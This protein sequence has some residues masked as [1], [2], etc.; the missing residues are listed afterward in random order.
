MKLRQ[1]ILSLAIV[2]LVA[3]GL[4]MPALAADDTQ[5]L[6]ITTQVAPTYTVVIPEATSGAIAY[7]AESTKVGAVSL[8]GDT[9]NLE[10]GYQVNVTLDGDTLNHAAGLDTIRYNAHFGTQADS[11][12]IALTDSTPTDVHVDIAAAE[13]ETATAGSYSGVLNFVIDYAPMA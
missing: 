3:A 2:S 5:S 8:A 1:T 13:W 10:P 4:A 9:L 12:T 7:K 11:K 6:T